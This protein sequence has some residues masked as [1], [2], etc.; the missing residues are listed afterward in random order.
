MIISNDLKMVDVDMAL[1]LM[2]G[3]EQIY[4]KIVKTFLH[5]QKNLIEDIEI[6]LSCNYDEARRLVHS[7][8]GIS[9]N[10]G[11]NQL[12]E[13]SAE[14]EKAIMECDQELIAYYF[15][16]FKEVFKQ[17]VTDLKNIKFQ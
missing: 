14:L 13:V 12:Y 11:S 3:L 17:V 4:R 8:K 2:N 15:S 7:C 10:I 5:E 16:N 6:S 1:S 9:K